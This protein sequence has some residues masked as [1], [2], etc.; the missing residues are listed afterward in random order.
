[1]KSYKIQI[2]PEVLIYIER[3][4]YICE[5]YTSLLRIL[6]REI[7]T[8]NKITIEPILNKYRKEYQQNYIQLKLAI[9]KIIYIH[10]KKIPENVKYHID[11]N[12]GEML[13]E[14]DDE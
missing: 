3:L 1:M 8:E 5:S 12:E 13:L 2:K 4:N 14:F 11:F 9:D 7:S 6:T 10:F